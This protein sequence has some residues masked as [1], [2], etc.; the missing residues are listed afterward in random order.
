MIFSSDEIAT[1]MAAYAFNPDMQISQTRFRKCLVDEWNISL[2]MRIREIGC[3]QGDMTAVLA[4]AV[5]SDDQVTAVDLAN[6]AYGAPVCL[7]DSMRHLKQGPL[8]ESAF[9]VGVGSSALFD[10]PIGASVGGIDSGADR[11]VQ[12]E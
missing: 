8:G 5:G 9:F 12:T 11:G 6:P 10:R 4:D 2:G 7:G 1:M 3:G